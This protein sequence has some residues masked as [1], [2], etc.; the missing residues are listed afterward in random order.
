MRQNPNNMTDWDWIRH[1]LVDNKGQDAFG[2]AF[3]ILSALGVCTIILYLVSNQM[4]RALNRG[5]RADGIEPPLL[6]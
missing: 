4:F 2:F 6:T 5:T 3:S 1:E